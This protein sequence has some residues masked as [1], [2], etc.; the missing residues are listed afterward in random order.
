MLRA[1]DLAVE[2]PLELSGG[3]FTELCLWLRSPIGELRPLGWPM[4]LIPEIIDSRYR[5]AETALHVYQ[6]VE[7]SRPV[8]QREFIASGHVEWVSSREG[9]F[10]TGIDLGV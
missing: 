6:R 4:V 5:L 9:S 3:W 10:E 2:R 8:P 1:P 7:W